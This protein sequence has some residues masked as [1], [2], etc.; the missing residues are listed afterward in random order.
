MRWGVL[1]GVARICETLSL[2]LQQGGGGVFSCQEQNQKCPHSCLSERGGGGAFSHQEQNRKHPHSHRA[3]EGVVLPLVTEN[4][5]STLQAEAG[6]GGWLLSTQAREGVVMT[7]ARSSHWGN[8]QCLTPDE[9]PLC[10]CLE[11]G[12][13]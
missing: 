5:T 10:L 9:S 4:V 12:R 6:N 2:H 13:G 7:N 8:I 11:R 1:V 3:R